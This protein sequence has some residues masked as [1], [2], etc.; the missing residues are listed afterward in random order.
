MADRYNETARRCLGA[1][2]H[3]AHARHHRAV[4]GEHLVLGILTESGDLVEQCL[5]SLGICESAVR[6]EVEAA[7]EERESDPGTTGKLEY[8]PDVIAAMR[9]AAEEARSL[10]RPWV[11]EAHFLLGLARVVP[12]AAAT[13][14]SRAGVQTE[15]L[16]DAL[17]GSTD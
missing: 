16:R 15:A 3:E 11:N 8:E 1:A 4:G 10:G 5:G 6:G 13:A 2:Y 9:F 7:L 14:L 17:S 12:S